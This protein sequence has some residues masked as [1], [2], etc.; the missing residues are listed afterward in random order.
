[1]DFHISFPWV[2]TTGLEEI[3]FVTFCHNYKFVR[4]VKLGTKGWEIMG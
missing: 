2:R 3:V 1:M 4:V